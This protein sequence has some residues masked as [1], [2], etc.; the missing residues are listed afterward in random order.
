[1]TDPDYIIIG[2][3]DR[4][5]LAELTRELADAQWAVDNMWIAN[6]PWLL[7]GILIGVLLGIT[8]II[9]L[10]MVD[11]HYLNWGSGAI[12]IASVVGMGVLAIMIAHEMDIRDVMVIQAEIDQIKAMW[13]I[14]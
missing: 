8:L 5:R 11:V 6:T 1:M 7:L 12:L 9:L 10:D 13:G 2:V 4:L 14:Q 3:E